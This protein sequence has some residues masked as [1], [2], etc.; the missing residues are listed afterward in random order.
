MFLSDKLA[1]HFNSTLFTHLHTHQFELECF[2]RFSKKRVGTLFMPWYFPE[3]KSNTRLCLTFRG[4]RLCSSF[5]NDSV[6]H[7]SYQMHTAMKVHQTVKRI[8]KEIFCQAMTHIYLIW[9]DPAETEEIWNFWN[10]ILWT[11]EHCILSHNVSFCVSVLS[12]PLLPTYLPSLGK[13]GYLEFYIAPAPA[14]MGYGAAVKRFL[15]VMAMVWAGSQIT[16][17]VRAGGALTLTPFVDRG[18]SWFTHKFKFQTREGFHGNSGTLS[19]IGRHCIF[20]HHTALGMMLLSASFLKGHLNLF[21]TSKCI[22]S[23][24]YPIMVLL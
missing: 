19:W 20:G 4:R 16:K 24:Y 1:P 14:K 5:S 18:L 6:S 17:L 13:G 7:Q 9:Q 22:N 8:R 3:L 23:F 12:S 21:V 2:P 10:P 15:K 11:F